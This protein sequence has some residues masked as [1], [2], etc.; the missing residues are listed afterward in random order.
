MFLCVQAKPL[1]EASNVKELADP[2]LE[3]DYDSA[4]IKRVMVT[5]SMCVHQTPSKR[6]YMDRVSKK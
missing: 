4:E 2:R 6:P 5:A 3:D 1:L